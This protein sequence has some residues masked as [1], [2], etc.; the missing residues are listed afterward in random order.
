MA[1]PRSAALHQ[2]VHQHRALSR[3]GITERFFTL[4]F[5][6]FVYNQIWEDPRVDIEALRLGPGSRVVTIAS[7][8]CNILN[9]LVEQ[10]KSI[11]AV[12]LNRHHMHLT[13]LKLAA[14][15]HLPTHDDFFRF[16]GSASDKLN[17]I[18]YTRYVREHLDEDTRRFWE[19]RR[20][21]RLLF[22]PRIQ[23]F[24]RNFYNH[25]K[26]GSLMRFVHG[27]A[28]ITR[29][30]PSRLL[31]AQSL[32]E[33]ATLFD[34]II[35]PFFDNWVVRATGRLPVVAASLG[36]PPRQ[37]TALR[38]GPDVGI[39]EVYRERV[40]RLA[41]HFPI[42]DNYF[43]WQAFSRGYDLESRR[44][45]PEYLRQEHWQALRDAA[46]RIDTHI[47]PMTRHLETRDA[48][49]LDAFVLLDAQDWMKPQE[50]EAL[51]R[52]I[53]RTGSPGARVIFRTAG[54]QSPIEP[55]LPDDLMSRFHYHA[56]ESRE[57]YDRDRSAI[58]GGFHL[59]S[60]R[61]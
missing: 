5:G 3:T 19:S 53:A 46:D 43:S 41:C 42:Q 22:G 37:V 36:I 38:G 1:S 28:R 25:A 13:R 50:I 52:E 27:L 45:M 32:E 34:E 60:L 29:R 23:Y 35:A 55:A 31:R 51:W 39:V 6:G 9:Y 8:G 20:G 33:Q 15:R 26:F 56:G 49:S 11:T 40:R 16:F 61:D 48:D 17:P 30:D 54:S 4:W 58:Y 10:P 59:Y 14:L 2:A 21:S 44:A 47:I 57:L 24:T 12:D 18:N 7:G